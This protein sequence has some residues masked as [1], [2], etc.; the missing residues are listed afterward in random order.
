[1]GDRCDR[2]WGRGGLRSFALDG[3]RPVTLCQSCRQEAPA[4]L[5]VFREVF[6]RF[7]STKE[8]VSHY[9]A[10][11]EPEALRKLCNE[12]RL[13]FR[14]VIRAIDVHAPEP[15][16]GNGFLDFTRP[17]GYEM[18]DGGLA[19]R[20]EEAKTV[21]VIFEMYQ[22]GLGIAKICKELNGAKIRTKTGKAWASQTVANIL[23]NPLYAGFVKEK[24][25]L[26]PGRHRRIVDP[27]VFSDVQV[28]LEK[29]I[30]RPDQRPES[31]LFRDDRKAGKR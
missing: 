7:G 25:G 20:P 1:M 6:M 28:A 16:P 14:T 18:R 29:R 9:D 13:D 22:R 23:R 19:V 4:D 21:G 11:D 3:T 24:S 2:C 27:E 15:S 12:R 8:M 10:R 5:V 17:F 31:K 26:R 30:R